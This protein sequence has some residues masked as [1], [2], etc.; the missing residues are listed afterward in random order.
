MIHTFIQQRRVSQQR[1]F[2][3]LPLLIHLVNRVFLPVDFTSIAQLVRDGLQETDSA[4]C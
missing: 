4:Q 2:L 1:H 3:T